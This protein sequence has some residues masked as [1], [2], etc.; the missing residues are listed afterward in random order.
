MLIRIL[1]ILFM[2]SCNVGI[3]N[4][5]SN[6]VNELP[7]RSLQVSKTKQIH[8]PSKLPE[9]LFKFQ[10]KRDEY[11][12]RKDSSIS[13]KT[14]SSHSGSYRPDFGKFYVANDTIFIVENNFRNSMRFDNLSICKISKAEKLVT[15][16]FDIKLV[17]DNTDHLKV[18]SIVWKKR[19]QIFNKTKT[20][21]YSEKGYEEMTSAP[22]LVKKI[23]VYSEKYELIY[24]FEIDEN[25]RPKKYG[26]I[27]ELWNKKNVVTKGKNGI[28]VEEWDFK[29]EKYKPMK[30]LKYVG[31]E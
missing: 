13:S 16:N 31:P 29:N 27:I 18:K 1:L 8:K 21:I 10:I 2:F 14:W 6:T 19:P 25:W 24:R 23:I 4:C 12:F 3:V 17:G 22:I 11:V 28:Q 20:S 7:S 5:Q 15:D 26:Y 30:S 9:A